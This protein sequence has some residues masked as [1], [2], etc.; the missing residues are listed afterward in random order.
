MIQ[1]AFLEFSRSVRYLFSLSSRTFSALLRSVM[2]RVTPQDLHMAKTVQ[3]AKDWL[4]S[5]PD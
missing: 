4:V 3:E 2:F 1:I 5:Q